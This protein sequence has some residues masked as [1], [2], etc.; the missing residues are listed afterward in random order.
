[1]LRAVEDAEGGD[2]GGSKVGNRLR[3]ILVDGAPTSG[4]ISEASSDRDGN[5]S[6]RSDVPDGVDGQRVLFQVTVLPYFGR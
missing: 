1:L 5:M 4:V 6:F 3:V 2:N